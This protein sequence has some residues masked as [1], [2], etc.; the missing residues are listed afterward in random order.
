MCTGL[1]ANPAAVDT[2]CLGRRGRTCHFLD[3]RESVTQE[4]PLCGERKWRPTIF[5]CGYIAV[6]SLGQQETG[7]LQNG[8]LTT[9]NVISAGWFTPRRRPRRRATYHDAV[10]RESETIR[11]TAFRG[12]CSSVQSIE[13]ILDSRGKMEIILIIRLLGIFK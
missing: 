5:R 8:A 4:D 9:V 1:K 12:I 13:N 11:R 7:P 3:S 10:K 2:P 6:V